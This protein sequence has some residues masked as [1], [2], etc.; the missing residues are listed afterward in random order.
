MRGY[1]EDQGDGCTSGAYKQKQMGRDS[2]QHVRWMTTASASVAASELE[3]TSRYRDVLIGVKDHGGQTR[4]HSIERYLLAS[5]S[6][7]PFW[8]EHPLS[9]YVCDPEDA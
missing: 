2:H 8:L 3:P 6:F 1:A 9:F 4:H 7:H 5:F